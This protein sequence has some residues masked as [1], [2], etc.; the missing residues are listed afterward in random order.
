MYNMQSYSYTGKIAFCIVSELVQKT[1]SVCYRNKQTI[2]INEH[3]PIFI[4]FF[5]LIM[6]VLYSG[7]NTLACNS[8]VMS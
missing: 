7:V 1:V 3:T 6:C 8:E 2:V 4:Y 5:Y